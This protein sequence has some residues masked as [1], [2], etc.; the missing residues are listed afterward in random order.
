MLLL[1]VFHPDKRTDDQLGTWAFCQAV[2]TFADWI[3][4]H[5]P[6]TGEDGYW[7]AL[8]LVWGHNG[9]VVV[10]EQ[11]IVPTVDHINRLLYCQRPYCAYDFRLAHGVPWSE[12]TGG[13]GFGLAKFS[14]A[15]RSSIAA[16]PQVPHTPWPDTVPTVHLRLAPVHVHQPVVEHHHGL[17]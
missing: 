2:E 9:P 17:A 12:V 16:R 15:A 11:D 1:H 8:E 5:Y 6:T 7:R 14:E 3:F 10:L 4:V 13:H